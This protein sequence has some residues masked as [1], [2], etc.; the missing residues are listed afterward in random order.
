[1]FNI[2]SGHASPFTAEEPNGTAVCSEG[3][4]IV[5]SRKQLDGSSPTGI[6]LSDCINKQVEHEHEGILQKRFLNLSCEEPASTVE[7]HPLE[8]GC[9]IESVVM[10]DERIL[11]SIGLSEKA[12][13]L[14]D[15][16][17]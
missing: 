10:S 17:K 7:G 4:P 9:N 5:E 2:D 16:A 13:M 3:E 14:Q 15:S 1:M 6:G 12:H 11:S 8:M